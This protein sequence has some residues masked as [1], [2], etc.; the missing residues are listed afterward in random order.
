MRSQ[1]TNRKDGLRTG[2]RCDECEALVCP[3]CHECDC[4]GCDWGC[5][6]ETVL[7]KPMK[8]ALCNEMIEIKKTPEGK[9]YWSSGH[10]GM[11]LVDGRVCDACNK[12]VV[13]ERLSKILGF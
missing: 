3:D 5:S 10:N 2:E 12:K 1:T 11:P 13:E 9:V 4:A 8:C 6:Y 7:I